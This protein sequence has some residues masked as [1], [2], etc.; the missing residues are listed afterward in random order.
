MKWR[1]VMFVTAVALAIDAYLGYDALHVP[2]RAY[3]PE[4]LIND[5][6][7]GPVLFLSI[8]VSLGWAAL[9]AQKRWV[10]V[11]GLC[12]ASLLLVIFLIQIAAMQF[13]R[14]GL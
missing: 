3:P 11:L 13:P 10:R 14:A 1:L 12:I 4:N 9:A 8:P 5:T 7:Y 6:W 2:G